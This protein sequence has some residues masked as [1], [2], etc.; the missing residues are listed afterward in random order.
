MKPGVSLV[1]FQKNNAAL[2]RVDPIWKF[3]RTWNNPPTNNKYK[4]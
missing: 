3:A 2:L 4:T 1:Q